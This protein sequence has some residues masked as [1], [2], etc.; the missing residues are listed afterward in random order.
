MSLSLFLSIDVSLLAR[1]ALGFIDSQTTLKTLM[2]LL[3]KLTA[4]LVFLFFYFADYFFN[5]LWRMFF[6]A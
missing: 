6:L 5:L 1:V 2:H 4:V 3:P